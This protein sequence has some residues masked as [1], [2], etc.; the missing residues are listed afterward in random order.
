MK[1]VTKPVI[2][3]IGGN[4]DDHGAIK[5]AFRGHGSGS[6]RFAMNAEA[7]L[8]IAGRKPL[9]ALF[10]YET[11][12]DM[13]GFT[14]LEKFRKMKIQ[15]PLIMITREDCEASGLKAIKKGA[16][17]Y[18]VRKSGYTNTLLFVL[19]R[20]IARFKLDTERANLEKSIKKSRQMWMAIIDGIK[21]FIFIV[22]EESKIFGANRALAQ[23]FGKHPK[24]LLGKNI[25]ELFE[26]D[27]LSVLSKSVGS[28]L[29][30]TEEKDVLG[31]T[32]L[33]SSFPLQYNNT[34]LTICVM[35]NISEMRML[36]EQL[37]HSYKLA[38]LGLLISGI[39]HE[40]NNP[41]TGIITFA[42]VLRMKSKD[43]KIGAGLGRILDGAERCKRVIENLLTFS[44]QKVPSK[45]LESINDIIDRAVE[46][47]NYWLR[48]LNIDVAKE[49][50]KIPTALL[51][52]QQLQQVILNILLNAEQAIADAKRNDGNVTFTTRYDER[53]GNI[54]VEISDNGPGIPEDVISRVFDPFFTTKPVGTGTGLGLSIAHGVI[55]EHG[56]KIWVESS[57]GK[58]TTFFIDIPLTTGG[59]D[60]SPG[61]APPT[62]KSLKTGRTEYR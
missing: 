15:A 58:G 5:E 54:S 42:E 62:R 20:A 4:V 21:D 34:S 1:E 51:D 19:E 23:L 40:L 26:E 31:E 48:K 47:R 49:Y 45:S 25:K 35:K 11:L 32:Y 61:S 2:L 12:T 27:L 10:I 30:Q 59:K 44:R 41:I 16:K 60:K 46:L 18:V 24:D 50:G 55:A 13:D 6:L 53:N 8:D 39:A 33:I 29:P 9:K 57:R 56:G 3:F 36:K 14:L 7:G 28:E 17:D 37:Y 38:S 43:E 22:D 52:S